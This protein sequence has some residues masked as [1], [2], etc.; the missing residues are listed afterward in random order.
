MKNFATRTIAAAVIAGALALGGGAAVAA[1]I[2]HPAGV[3]S[4]PVRFAPIVLKPGQ[5]VTL[6]FIRSQP[7]CKFEDSNACGWD[8]GAR[9][10]G[11]GCSFYADRAGNV[12][13]V[14]RECRDR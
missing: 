4:V 10:N 7:A 2:A 8:A 13:Y 11:R 12:H 3:K 5:L 9:G 14:T 6:A 1:P